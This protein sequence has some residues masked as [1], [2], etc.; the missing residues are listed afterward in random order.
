[1]RTLG[2]V[3]A[4]LAVLVG[5]GVALAG[6]GSAQGGA[7]G[8][9]SAHGDANGFKPSQGVGYAAPPGATA[10]LLDIDPSRYSSIDAVEDVSGAYTGAFSRTGS[11]TLTTKSGYAALV[12]DGTTGQRLTHAAPPPIT[13]T[14]GSEK[15]IYL[16]CDTT[17]TAGTRMAFDVGTSG[18]LWA[19]LRLNG[20]G[21]FAGFNGSAFV[22]QAAS[23]DT[24]TVLAFNSSTTNT[25]TLYKNGSASSTSTA[26]GPVD[27]SSF[28]TI[29][30]NSTYAGSYVYTWSG[31]IYR[32]VID[33][34]AYSATLNT[35]LMAKYGVS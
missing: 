30:G 3:S 4:L 14:H 15:T 22:T 34:A 8:L 28:T 11:P 5:A 1:M 17:T 19:S 6:F 29:F 26:F 20:S 21:S 32:I 10:V 31:A 35:H 13:N 23:A 18:A 27:L 12:F 7:N 33:Q 24:I 25:V 2:A 9:K 16:V